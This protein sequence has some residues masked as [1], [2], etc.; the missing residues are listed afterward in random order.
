MA[1]AAVALCA[2]G[3][4]QKQSIVVEID[5]WGCDSIFVGAASMSDL[6][7]EEVVKIDTLV[8]QNGVVTID[9]DSIPNYHRVQL[10]RL[11]DFYMDRL[12]PD[13]KSIKII[14]LKGEKV[15]IKGE[16][17]DG[18]L[19]YSTSQFKDFEELYNKTLPYDIAA[20]SLNMI[21]EVGMAKRD[22]SI[23][24]LFDQRGDE[25]EKIR[26]LHVEYIRENPDT[27]FAA[28]LAT[29]INV[30]RFRECYDLLS[31]RVKEGKYKKT[32]FDAKMKRL[33]AYEEY[34]ASKEAGS[35]AVGKPA[36]DFT[37]PSLDGRKLSLSD[38]RGKWVILDFWGSWCGW[39]IKGVPEMKQFY[40]KYSDK[41]E[42]L[43]LACNDT[44]KAWRASVEEHKMNWVNLFD[45]QRVNSKYAIS[46]Y[47]TKILIDPE[48]VIRH[49]KSGDSKEY[50][51]EVIEIID[52]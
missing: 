3:G 21:I 47:P 31:D 45:D 15:A 38:F 43:G 14:A 35:V 49:I 51:D 12:I 9:L 20:D 46:S 34:M 32:F 11:K 5:G 42:I 39:C 16:L 25:Y 13:S 40:D 24:P 22:K 18:V 52:L 37:L 33:L 19:R 41:V 50:Y 29:Q 4:A 28:F 36:I 6:D 8:A 26:N 1:M 44:D 30:I 2:C 17:S 7:E 23:G 10:A 48:G 27:D